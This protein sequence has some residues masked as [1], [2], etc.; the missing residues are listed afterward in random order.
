MPTAPLMQ[1]P[2]SKSPDEFES[3]CTD[4]LTKIY[5]I[6]FTRYGRNGQGQDGIDIYTKIKKGKYNVAQC[7]NYYKP[8]SVNTLIKKIE[9]DVKSAEKSI[10]N[11]SNSHILKFIVMTSIDRDTKVQN[12]IININSTFD[13]IEVWFWEDIQQNICNDTSLLQ[14]YYPQFFNNSQLTTKTLNE[15]IANLNTLKNIAY[16]FNNN[17][18][19]YSV[20]C[21]PNDD[22]AVYNQ[23]L[24]MFSTASQLYALKDQ[25]YL[26]IQKLGII[27]TIEFILQSIPAFHDA[28]SDW[29]GAT[30]CYT[31]SNYLDYFRSDENTVKFINNC[32][33][34][35]EKLI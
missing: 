28:N 16:N 34:V 14:T 3:I 17:Y 13:D 12:T 32:E 2:R 20:A 8:S 19:N 35:V 9:A 15:I 31:I 21:N 1:I 18:K 10:F 5:N 25:W 26:Q 24:A 4:I 22:T 7:K 30:A 6:R 33:D 11:T 29:T 23:C 27:D